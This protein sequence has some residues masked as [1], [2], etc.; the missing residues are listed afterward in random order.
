MMMGVLDDVSESEISQE[1]QDHVSSV[2]LKLLL[3]SSLFG[4]ILS[5]D[6]SRARVH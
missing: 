3:S 1:N 2:C 6:Q 5:N 4:Y